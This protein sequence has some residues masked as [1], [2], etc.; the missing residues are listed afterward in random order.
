MVSHQGHI[1]HMYIL[2]GEQYV[3]IVIGVTYFRGG[4]MP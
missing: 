1:H 2:P 3:S 4:G